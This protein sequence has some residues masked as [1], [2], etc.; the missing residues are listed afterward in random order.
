MKKKYCPN[1]GNL[2]ENNSDVCP[3]CGNKIN[4]GGKVSSLIGSNIL[5]KPKLITL[6]ILLIIVF[7]SVIAFTSGMF[8]GDLV[9]VTYSSISIGYSDTPFGGAL[10]SLDSENGEDVDT[11]DYQV[12]N[13]VFKFSLMPKESITRITGVSLQNVQVFFEDGGSENWGDFVF[14]NYKT[15]YIQDMNYNFQI[16]KNLKRTGE[17][18]DEYY[19]INHIKGDIVINTTNEN[20]KIIGHIDEDIMPNN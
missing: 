19:K 18:I 8:G 20:N 6:V 4:G 12:G 5:Y 16:S 7:I 3:S 2:L 9:D 10:S 17:T 13:A 15:A 14:K 1:C 11:L